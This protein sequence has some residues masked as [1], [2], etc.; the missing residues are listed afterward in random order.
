MESAVIKVMAVAS[1][2]INKVGIRPTFPR[3]H[4]KRKYIITPRIVSRFG[5]Y[6]PLNV[7]K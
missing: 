3:T 4:P 6:T 1:V 2:T 5:V 7:P